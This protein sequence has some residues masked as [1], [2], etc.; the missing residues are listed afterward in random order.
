[1][2]REINVF[3]IG[4]K[5]VDDPLLL[6]LFIENIKED[7]NPKV[8]IHG[9]G[10]KATEIAKKLNITTQMAEG[11]RITDGDSLEVVTMVYGGLINKNLVALLQSNGINALGLSGADG[12]LIKSHKREAEK[13]D[14]GYVG[15]IDYVNSDLL[16]NILSQNIT[17]IICP[18]TH[19]GNGQILNTN[20]DTIA[21]RIAVALSKNNSVKL[22]YAFELKGVMKDLND[23][24]SVISVLTQSDMN[25]LYEQEVINDGMIPK[26]KN[27]YDALREGVGHV[28]IRHVGGILNENTGTTL[29]L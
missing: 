13:F 28:S 11:R 4:G 14:Y 16:N 10:K 7:P 18:L 25:K 2:N 27:G 3:K 26:L 23:S 8:I 17:P 21:S 15:D 24:D 9:G 6:N 29:E 20:A 12:N 22:V 5:V 1:M 19:D